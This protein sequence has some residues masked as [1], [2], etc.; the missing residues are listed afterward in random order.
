MASR[1]S[2]EGTVYQRT[3]GRWAAV[4]T[5]GWVGTKRQRKILYGRTRAEAG[6]KLRAALL[7]QENG[8]IVGGR[9]PTVAQWLEHWLTTIARERVRPST[10]AGYRHYVNDWLVPHLGR[11]RLDKLTAEH[12]EQLYAHMREQGKA[13]ATILQAH[14]IL[15]RALKVAEQRGRVGRNVATKVDAPSLDREEAAT[16]DTAQARAVLA[17]A[18]GERNAPRWT[19]ALALGLRQGEALGLTWDQVDLVSG[20]L[21]VRQALQR[22]TGEGLV[23]VRPKSRAGP[24]SVALPPVLVEQL[25]AH[26]AAQLRERLELGPAWTGWEVDGQAVDLVFTQPTGRPIDP[27]AD[28]TAATLMLVQG[29]HPRVVMETLGHSSIQLTLG[30]YSHVAPELSHAAAALMNTALLT[31][32]D[33]APAEAAAVTAAVRPTRLRSRRPQANP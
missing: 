25:R 14:R 2:G 7:A 26:R 3:D 1:S 16:L 27:K 15:S 33:E 32:P 19:I 30:T 17:A 28:Y 6:S 10:Y 11:H 29:V 13:P 4:I 21:R 24:R 12:L 31:P 20:V 22:V 8:D 23:L 18:A 5:T 9:T